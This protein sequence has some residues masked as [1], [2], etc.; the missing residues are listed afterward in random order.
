MKKLL[1]SSLLIGLSFS[2]QAKICEIPLNQIEVGGIRLMQ[3]YST[4]YKLHPTAKISKNRIEMLDIDT[5]FK[6]HGI[7]FI[8]AIEYDA[9][10]D[11]I[12][13]YSLFY[14]GGKYANTDTPLNQFKSKILAISKLPQKDWQLSKDKT[15]YEYRC[16]DYQISIQQ[17][18]GIDRGSFG[19]GVS[20]S[21]RYSFFYNK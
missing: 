16:D 12:I 13:G 1:I 15:E 2:T 9:R 18:H 5:K 4:F 21:S 3:N 19:P 17:D 14:D 10:K 20:V 6:Q 8:G 7:T 11:R